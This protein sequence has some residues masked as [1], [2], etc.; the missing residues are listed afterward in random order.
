MFCQYQN[1]KFLPYAD[2]NK[3]FFSNFHLIYMLSS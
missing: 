3:T 1:T 2:K